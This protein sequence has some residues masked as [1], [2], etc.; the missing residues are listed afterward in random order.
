ME[1]ILSDAVTVAGKWSLTR[2]LARNDAGDEVLCE[3]VGYVSPSAAAL[4]PPKSEVTACGRTGL[5]IS[6]GTSSR[7]GQAV[8]TKVMCT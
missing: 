4:F 2:Q 7:P 6:L 8:L 5:V 1:P 3:L